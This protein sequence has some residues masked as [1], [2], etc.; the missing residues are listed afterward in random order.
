MSRVYSAANEIL[1]VSM[2]RHR[3][4]LITL[5]LSIGAAFTA[6][7][8]A[9]T[10][11]PR[12]VLKTTAC[13]L[14]IRIDYEKEKLFGECRLTFVNGS[15]EPL[16]KVPLVLYRLMKITSVK[17]D[18]GAPL[19]C[20]QR[21]LA[22][23]DWD[24]YQANI[25]EAVLK[26]PLPAGEKKTIDILYEG[27]LA[28]LTETGMGYVKDHVDKD[29]T[30]IR[31]DCLAYPMIGYP[32]WTDTRA[33]GMQA[34]DYDVSVTVP[35]SLVVANGGRATGVVTK[36]GLTTY[37]YRNILPAWRIDLAVAKYGVIEDRE[38]GFKVFH[39]AQDRE[40]AQRVLQALRE[41]TALFSGWFGPAQGAA[42]Y[43]VI[44]IPEGFGS[45][46]DVTSA[47]QTRSAFQDPDQLVQLYHEVSHRWN[48]RSL[49][50]QPPRFE[51]EGLAMLLQNLARE[52]L[53]KKPGSLDK[54]AERLRDHFRR[55]C[56]EDIKAKTTAMIDYGKE[57]LTDVSYS[58]GMLFFY[59]LYKLA[60]EEHFLKAVG[61]FYQTYKDKGATAAE[62]VSYLRKNIKLPLDAFFKDWVTGAASSDDL[63][64]PLSLDEITRKY[65]M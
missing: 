26:V 61:G 43:S 56:K 6:P 59:V 12:P 39:F 22:F 19:P 5:C 50:P 48:V 9:E 33:L 45:Q 60:G 54:G 35:D 38:G 55:E 3:I 10:A 58:K 63:L 16:G 51:S 42:V 49:D 41:S 44:E 30:I 64:G 34:F 7:A 21:I 31:P 15:R 52:K 29:F 28:G 25:I 57:K 62:F 11:G 37:S 13:K 40:G 17:D 4:L 23:E 27:Y 20:D 18:D 14:D 65:R 46:A 1:R 36:D 32:S 47:L 2:K 53:E 8:L 24:K